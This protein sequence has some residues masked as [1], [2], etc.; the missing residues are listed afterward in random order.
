[1][2]GKAL[3]SSLSV[4]FLD[5][6][7][8][9]P[10][11]EEMTSNLDELFKI[12]DGS[13]Y[14]NELKKAIFHIERL[15]P[16]EIPTPFR[17]NCI[18]LTYSGRYFIFGSNEGR[19][20]MIDKDSKEIVHEFK[21]DG[22]N[23]YSICIYLNDS[24]LVAAGKDGKIRKFSLPGFELI[25][26]LEGHSREVNK[27]L[28]SVDQSQIFSAS[29]DCTV[30]TWN[31][32][33]N[34]SEILYS[35]QKAVL[36]LDRSNC[37]R[38]LLSGGADKK[39]IIFDL[40]DKKIQHAL[41]EFG[42]AVWAIKLSANA[43]YLAAGDANATIK[44]WNFPTL[45]LFKTFSGHS[46]RISHLNFLNTESALIS[47]SNDTTIRIW[48]LTE[49]KNEIVLTG[50]TDWVKQFILSPNNKYLYSIA[51]NFK[52]LTW[53][54]PKFDSSCRI[55]LHNESIN[56]LCVLEKDHNN[57]YDVL[58][59]ADSNDIHIWNLS[60]KAVYKTIEK[61]LE[62]TAVCV[63][64]K[65]RSVLIAYSNKEIHAW[66]TSDINSK[67]IVKHTSTVKTMLIS[68][69]G[70][71]LSIGDTNFRV[72]VYNTRTFKSLFV[73]RRHNLAVTCLSYK[74][75][76]DYPCKKLFSG[77]GD[78]MIYLYSLK[79]S[80]STKLGNHHFPISALTISRCQNLLASGDQSG[81]LKLWDLQYKSCIKSIQAHQDNITSIYFTKNEKNFWVSSVDQILSL[82]NCTSYAL[83]TQITC[84]SPILTL[85]FDSDE[86]NIILAE[87]DLLYFLPNIQT[88]N[89]F[90]IYGPGNGYY[91]IMKYL[92]DMCEGNQ[93]E[94]DPELDKWIIVPFEFNA[95]HFYAYFNFPLHMKQAMNSESPF[96]YS[97]SNITPIHIAIERNFRDCIN[98]IVKSV[99]FKMVDDP[100]SA[101]F[102]EDQLVKLNFLGFRGLD[103]LYSSILNKVTDKK[104]PKFVTNDVKLPIIY[105]ADNFGID[106]SKFFSKSKSASSGQ[107][108][109]F[110]QSALKINTSIGSQD[111]IDFLESI[112][113]CP[114]DNIFTTPIIR[115]LILYKWGYVKWILLPQAFLYFLY[116]LLLSYFLIFKFGENSL[117]F[118]VSI[119][120]LNIILTGYEIL[121]MILTKSSYFTDV[122]NYIDMCRF[123][124]CFAYCIMYLTEYK[125]EVNKQVLVLLTFFTMLRGIS[126]FRLFDETR[127]L[128]NLLSEVFK[129]MTSFLILLTYS[130]YSFA[131]IY[132]IMVNNILTFSNHEEPKPFSEYIAV[133]YLLNLG[134]FDT[135]S[136][137]AFEWMIFFFASVI[138]PLI[139]LNLLISLMG[140]TFGRVKEGQEIA[141][142]KELTGMVIEGE[143]LMFCKRS[144]GTRKLLQICKEE[145]VEACAST[146]MERVDKLKRRAKLIQGKLNQ[147]HE[148]AKG[149]I[150]NSIGG[151]SSK[152]D[153]MTTLIEQINFTQE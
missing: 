92:M 139:M 127:Y 125:D 3:M 4:G 101:S 119:L 33:Q 86:N 79:K 85:C 96:F 115:E 140:D 94:H 23:V 141:D 82:W 62:I 90:C 29:D 106:S 100:Y 28:L 31:D 70:Q 24:F 60:S 129:D 43:H 153:E 50:H 20:A 48:S 45:D 152:L 135:D 131:L 108:I 68:P 30:R 118:V 130:T 98:E 51:E 40:T 26:V 69:D 104:L 144:S 25:R 151:V 54:L 74:K 124:T 59:S 93:Q 39:I 5:K 18:E 143:Y 38:Y 87:N 95:L 17:G 35:H 89:Q 109:S 11:K 147:R 102:L 149:E 116:T 146:P 73:Y 14:V 32:I 91:P 46:K 117:F 36:C 15:S 103:E 134:D 1:M 81:C 49:D 55:K 56:T 99:R 72:T 53:Y 7:K 150:K 21:Q 88:M 44:V 80:K 41:T 132:F 52:I 110:Y 142:I 145:Q 75:K 114:N 37:G 71:F 105:L 107:P 61:S 13:S 58:V 138:N 123:S 83:I 9:A 27:I 67:M 126:Y 136:Y 84:K 121:Q 122:W 42:G 113:D 78:N 128:I 19:I 12:A 120:T 148:E 111:S 64:Q 6:K 57:S 16:K 77:G 34:T 22:G 8:V 76:Q 2:L 65:E 137:G 47:S 97:K 112:I 10:I 66:T 63:H 133:A